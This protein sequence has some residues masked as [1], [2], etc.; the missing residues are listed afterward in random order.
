MTSLVRD[1]AAPA[2]AKY[3]SLA[4]SVGIFKNPSQ[5][6]HRFNHQCCIKLH[7]MKPVME[8]VG[9]VRYRCDKEKEEDGESEDKFVAKSE[10]LPLVPAPLEVGGD[11]KGDEKD[12]EEEGLEYE[13]KEDRSR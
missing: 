5:T 3:I 9:Q 13:A 11:A 10:R 6:P 7:E 12:P 4:I 1:V 2:L 8:R